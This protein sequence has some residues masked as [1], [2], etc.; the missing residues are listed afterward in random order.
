MVFYPTRRSRMLGKASMSS[1]SYSRNRGIY[2]NPLMKRKS[3]AVV[4]AKGV[5]GGAPQRMTP[6]IPMSQEVKSRD[7]SY[8]SIAGLAG[9][10]TGISDNSLYQIINGNTSSARIG[11]TIRVVGIL[12][13]G[14]V[15]TSTPLVGPN[16]LPFT[17]DLFW[18][19]QCNG[20]ATSLTQVYNSASYLALPNADYAHRFEFIK[21]IERY[22]RN[23]PAD[24]INCSIICN[25]LVNFD[26]TA[27]ALT[28]LEGNNL[29][30]SFSSQ[31]ESRF[32]GNVRILY[33]D[34]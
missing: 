11:R 26:A 14:I 20:A 19:K 7:T 13:R 22:N 33:V 25:K 2:R 27:G 4:S 21:R 28:D 10:W 16:T 5:P 31:Q 8:V 29:I 3:R 30:M 6:G 23:D 24:S 18:D 34:A 1:R 9:V 12:V 32:S 17:L 15:N